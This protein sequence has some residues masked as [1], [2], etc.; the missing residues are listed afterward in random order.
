[1]P[2]QRWNEPDPRLA[3][4]YEESIRQL[5]MQA[6]SL[7]ELRGRISTLMAAGGVSTSFLGPA[8]LEGRQSLPLLAVLAIGCL[9]ILT[10]AAIWILRP[11]KWRL[12]HNPEAIIDV[13]VDKENRTLRDTHRWLAK[14]NHEFFRTNQVQLDRLYVGFEVACGALL[15]SII[16]WLVLLGE[17]P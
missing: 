2:E 3:V 11:Y 17:S 9:A 10:I 14:M 5:D 1:M 16:F 6:S 4:A 7:D 12:T 13:Y 8:A 15:A